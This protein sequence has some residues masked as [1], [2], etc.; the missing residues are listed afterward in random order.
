VLT[1]PT[2]REV[3]S[4]I[5]VTTGRERWVSDPRI[6]PGVQLESVVPAVMRGLAGWIVDGDD[7]LVSALIGAGARRRRHASTM[8]Y[9]LT[10]A[11]VPDE[12]A[13]PPLP[14]GLSFAPVDPDPERLFATYVRAYPPGHPD[15]PTGNTRA[16]FDADFAP[17]LTGEALGRLLP[18]SGS[19]LDAAVPGRAVAVCLV[20]DWPDEGPWISEV[21][22][23]PAPRYAGIGAALLRRT[24]WLGSRAGLRS[25]GLAVTVGNPAQRVYEKVGFRILSTALNCVIPDPAGH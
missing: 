13:A 2:G 19:V 9:D 21:F 22:R 20:N 7:E 8:A 25:I 12:W 11:P 16:D 6:P 10:A 23:D 1:D 14:P 3:L 18:V 5:P 24:L 4:Y 15:A 17:L